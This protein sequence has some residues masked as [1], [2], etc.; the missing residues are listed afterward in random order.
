MWCDYCLT[1]TGYL[2]N[3][4]RWRNLCNACWEI[5]DAGG[6]PSK[7]PKPAGR[8]GVDRSARDT[9]GDSLPFPLDPSEA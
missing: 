5:V 7:M 3:Q 6:D 9:V 4:G 1:K 8:T 2:V